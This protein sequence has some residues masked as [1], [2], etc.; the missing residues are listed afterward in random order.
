MPAIPPGRP[1]HDLDLSA[2][3]RVGFRPAPSRKSSAVSASPAPTASRPSVA[4]SWTRSGAGRFYTLPF[5]H[6]GGLAA[7]HVP[8][9]RPGHPVHDRELRLRGHFGRETVS[10]IRTFESRRR[11]RFD[12]YMIYGERAGRHR[13]LPRHSPAPGRRYRATVD[14]QGGLCLRSGAQRFYEGRWPSAFPKALSGIA[15]VREW[16]DESQA[17]F[18]IAVD[19]RN[20]TWG[21]LFG[22]PGASPW[23]GSR[24]SRAA[25]RGMCCRSG[26]RDA[27]RAAIPT[28]HPGGSRPRAPGRPPILAPGNRP[29]VVLAWHVR[30]DAPAR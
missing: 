14:D 8:R 10:W 5:L 23:N 29:V 9:G 2:G 11:R 18:R 20:R 4:G 1:T 28:G 3:A 24:W 27:S 22:Y 26:R 25:S 16:Y 21:R 6:L 12:A 17:R 30:P 15:E 7:D 13:R 19:V